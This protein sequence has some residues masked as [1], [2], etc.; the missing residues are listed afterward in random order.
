M[1]KEA[2]LHIKSKHNGEIP[3]K[4]GSN[5]CARLMQSYADQEVKK[6]LEEKLKISEETI[7]EMEEEYYAYNLSIGNTFKNGILKALEHLK[8][9]Q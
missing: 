8:Q 1:S 6:A 5:E 9:N 7:K 2:L 3:Y 4:Y